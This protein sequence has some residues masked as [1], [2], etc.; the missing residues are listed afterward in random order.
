MPDTVFVEAQVLRTKA[1]VRS[2]AFT[3]AALQKGVEAMLAVALHSNSLEVL[4]LS[5]VIYFWRVYA[6]LEMV[7]LYIWAMHSCGG[8]LTLFAHTVMLSTVKVYEVKGEGNRAA[9]RH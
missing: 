5:A 6:C 8:S 2:I 1:K 3:S 7:V 4:R 9:S